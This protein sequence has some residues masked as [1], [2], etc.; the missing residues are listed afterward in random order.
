[1]NRK[2]YLVTGGCGFIGVNLIRQ[3]RNLGHAVRVFDNLTTGRRGDIEE[4]GVELHLG[5][6]RNRDQISAALSGIDVVVHLAAHTR[7]VE[8]VEDPRL[9]FDVNACGTMN[10]LEA[11]RAAG[12]GKF[13]FAST[14][15]AILG[16][17]TPPVH[18]GMVPKP[19]S[20]YGASKL[21]GE[22]YCSA[23]AGAYGLNTVTLRFANV[24]GPY[25]YHKGSV[26]AQFFKN[27]LREEIL[28]VYGDGSQT[29]DFVFVDDLVN[30]ILLADE[31]APRG[32]VFQIASGRETSVNELIMRMK[33]VLGDEKLRVR[34]EPARAG[35]I[36]RNYASIEKASRM[37]RFTPRV[38]LE[39]GLNHT[40][41][42]FLSKSGELSVDRMAMQ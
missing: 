26:V 2:R 29:R 3:L 18:E 34:Y 25:S 33:R 32:E 40:W 38:A 22:G 10:V 6:I 30:A 14:G 17:Q 8:S 16:E 37:I 21:A 41:E 12:V 5:D 11:S 15:G 24:Y 20:P 39:E 31:Y 42:W 13:I 4:L 35:E 7:V 23:F 28:T 19:V 1:M 36:T 27:V 9:N